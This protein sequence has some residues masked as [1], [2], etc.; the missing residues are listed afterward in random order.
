MTSHIDSRSVDNHKSHVHRSNLHSA[1]E[2]IWKPTDRNRIQSA[3]DEAVYFA[4]S[5]A[6]A[7]SNE[8]RERAIGGGAARFASASST[9]SVG[10][11]PTSA[12]CA[13]GQPPS[14]PIAES[15]R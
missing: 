14:P 5:P 6:V 2:W 7:F 8:S 13:N 3:A 9:F 15:K 1:A 10:I 4:A 12:S 11:F